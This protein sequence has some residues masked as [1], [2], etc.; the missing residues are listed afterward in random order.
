[1]PGNPVKERNSIKIKA[2]WSNPTDVI[3]EDKE[4]IVDTGAEITTVT[5]SN[6][7]SKGLTFVGF[8]GVS[9]VGTDTTSPA[10]SGGTVRFK[11]LDSKGCP[12][13][14]DCT[15][16]VTEARVNLL[17]M[18]QLAPA[19]VAVFTGDPPALVSGFAPPAERDC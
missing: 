13:F 1:M 18:D 12:K 2:R 10:W 15:T 14:I 9:G 19:K 17:G 11:T 7:R 4:F 3:E 8:R 5:P 16:I 6:T